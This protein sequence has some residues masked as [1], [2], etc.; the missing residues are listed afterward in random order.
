MPRPPNLPGREAWE[1]VT[2]LVILTKQFFILRSTSSMIERP[3]QGNDL[4]RYWHFGVK[5]IFLKRNRASWWSSCS[6]REQVSFKAIRRALSS[7]SMPSSKRG[8]ASKLRFWGETTFMPEN[9]LVNEDETKLVR[10]V[11]S[12]NGKLTFLNIDTEVKRVLYW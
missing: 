6:R 2:E 10:D 8:T 11:S 12:H 3:W 1:K 7:L 9:W 4:K 5:N